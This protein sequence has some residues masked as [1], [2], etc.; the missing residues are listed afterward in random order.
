MD[1]DNEKWS[2]Q[3]TAEDGTGQQLRNVG[4]CLGQLRLLRQMGDEFVRCIGWVNGAY[5][6]ILLQIIV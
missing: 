2:Y 3:V 6:S 1:V 5:V 4:I